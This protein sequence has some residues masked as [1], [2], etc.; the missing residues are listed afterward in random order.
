MVSDTELPQEK[1]PDAAQ[2]PKC[3]GLVTM[4]EADMDTAA[5]PRRQAV[6]PH[7][8]IEVE[9]SFERLQPILT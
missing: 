1:L 5:E 4:V 3:D 9:K 7:G 2:Y 8:K 6:M